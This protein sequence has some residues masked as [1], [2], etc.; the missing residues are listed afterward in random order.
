MMY[1]EKMAVAVKVNNRV[2]R[3][4]KDQVY[5]PFN[6][7]YTLF[8]KNLNTRRAVV[9]IEIDGQNVTNDGLVVNANS[10]VDLERFISDNLNEGYRFK[11]VERTAKIEQHRGGPGV[12]DGLIRIEWEYEKDYPKTLG[13][14]DWSKIKGST[15]YVDAVS[16]TWLSGGSYDP[17]SMK[18]DYYFA[19]TARGA[20]SSFASASGDYMS[21]TLLNCST[22]SSAESVLRSM[23]P[24]SDIGITVKGSI[25]E[26][27]FY[28]VDVKTDGVKHV[29]VLKLVGDIGGKPVVEPVTVKTKA[30]CETCGLVNKAT[31]KFCVECG[32]NLQI[33]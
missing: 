29:M 33:I 14:I 30:K 28:Q 11:F 24:Q 8:I 17:T 5:I 3:E 25:S 22:V 32:T 7:E 18:E 2:L 13:G 20:G 15:G 23:P 21:G 4:F 10:S 9:K 16:N 19:Q 6:E 12:E 26:Q 1:Q 27:R 31:S